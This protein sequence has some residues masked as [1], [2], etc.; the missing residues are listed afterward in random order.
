MAST[1][2]AVPKGYKL[3][4][5]FDSTLGTNF[6]STACPSFFATLL[7]DPTFQSCAPFSLLLTTSTGFFQAERS[8]YGL[9]PYVLNAS[10]TAPQTECLATMSSL[11]HTIQLKNT[12]GP[13]LALGNPLAAEA[14]QGF[15]GYELMREAGCARNNDTAAQYCFAEASA[16]ADPSDLYYYYLPE[17]TTLPSGSTPTCDFCTQNLLG[18][19]ARYA[20]NATLAIARTYASGRTAASLACGP[21]FAPATAVGSTES[22]ACGRALP[23]APLAAVLTIAAA[24]LAIVF[25]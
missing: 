1:S 18:I 22:S 6:T 15:Q 10:C 25:S 20:R 24:V 3:P 9:L 16:K 14:L 17:G 12:C 21:N 2:T 13:D 23:T 11:A 8:P 19:Y 7:A 5:A 4:Q